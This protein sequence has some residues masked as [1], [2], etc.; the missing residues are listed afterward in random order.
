MNKE[1]VQLAVSA[2]LELLGPN[3][4]V[5]IPAKLNDGVFILKQLLAAIAQGHIGLSSTTQPEIPAPSSP[6]VAEA[7]KKAVEQE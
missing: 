7:V 1:Q 5:S 3:S 2:G 6:Q 4:D